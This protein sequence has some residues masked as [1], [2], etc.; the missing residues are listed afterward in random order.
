MNADAHALQP[1]T[2]VLVVLPVRLA[3]HCLFRA[4]RVTSRWQGSQL[5][6]CVLRDRS[7]TR[8]V[9]YT[10]AHLTIPARQGLFLASNAIAD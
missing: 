5:A 2:H 7:A 10:R 1:S 6:P 3:L 4:C 8:L 9:R